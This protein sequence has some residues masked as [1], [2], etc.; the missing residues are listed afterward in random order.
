MKQ[1]IFRL[2]WLIITVMMLAF[3]PKEVRAQEETLGAFTVTKGD[4]GECSFAD[5]KLTVKAGTVT[6][7]TPEQTNQT[8]VLEG[9][10][11]LIL[12]GVNINTSAAPPIDV[13]GNDAVIELA[14]NTQN[15][16]ESTSYGYAGI[17]VDVKSK[18]TFTGSGELDVKNTGSNYGNSSCGIGGQRRGPDNYSCGTIIFDLDGTITAQGGDRAAGIGTCM[19]QSGNTPVYGCILIKKGIINATGGLCASGI[20]TG[21]DGGGGSVKIY[22]EGG[23]ITANGNY[24]SGGIGNGL[25]G[26][27]VMQIAIT[28]GQIYG[29][30]KATGQAPYYIQLDQV[31]IGPDATVTD[32]VSEYKNGIVFSGNPKTA[33]MKGDVIIPSDV[34]LTIDDGETLTIPDGRTLT[35][36]EGGTLINNGAIIEKGTIINNGTLTNNGATKY[37]RTNLTIGNY[38]TIC[39]PYAV[40]EKSGAEFFSIAGKKIED[41]K[42][43]WLVLKEVEGDLEA[44]KPYIFKATADKLSCTYSMN[45]AVESPSRDKGLIGCF[46]QIAVP[47][48]CYALK[49]NVIYKC[50]A[51]KTWNIAANRAYIN[52]GDVSE[53]NPD[54]S[55]SAN[56]VV[57]M[58]V[59]GGTT[60]IDAVRTEQQDGVYYNM[61]GQRVASPS[62]GIY[63]VN[64]KKVIMK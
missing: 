29:N 26:Q 60:G 23:T 40:T 55:S 52:M 7:S 31:I 21:P 10:A 41:S 34:I 39:L 32:G 28:G 46:T 20:G 63:I 13:T 57:K 14:A 12:A 25:N 1:K 5:N 16:L 4:G 24:G 58:R 42:V 61:Q 27:T 9:T 50:S 8:I 35:I 62:H 30:V 19:K 56:H 53:Y 11:R 2:G 37:E 54:A 36:E 18:V 38:G 3:V 44:G 15:T 51:E 45:N 49:D 48:N 22:V 47:E 6:V 43:T 17:H 59:S 64:G 33:T